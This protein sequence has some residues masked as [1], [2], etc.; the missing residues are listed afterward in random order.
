VKFF[1]KRASPARRLAAA[2]A[3]LALTAVPS[4]ARAHDV[5]TA[6]AD[7]AATSP[8]LHGVTMEEAAALGFSFSPA[9]TTSSGSM[10]FDLA[11]GQQL[12]ITVPVGTVAFGFDYVATGTL[13]PFGGCSQMGGCTLSGSGFYGA[14]IAP[15]LE[16]V[17][18]DLSDVDPIGIRADTDTRLT[19][20]NFVVAQTTVPEPATVL[21]LGTGIAALGG[22]GLARR[23]R[24]LPTA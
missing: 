1:P 8:P 22:V 17:G 23:R 13:T 11:A 7:L 15:F 16:I 18:D 20:S 4:T 3:A 2:A 9:G 12:Q 19:I 14:R 21:L 24:G 10:F 5:Y 6:Y